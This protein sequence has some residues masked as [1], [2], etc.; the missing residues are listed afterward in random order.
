MKKKLIPAYPGFT[1][2][3]I[4]FTIDDGIIKWDEKFISICRPYGI[5]GTFNLCSARMDREDGFYRED[6]GRTV[7]L[8]DK[9][10]FDRFFADWHQSAMTEVE[11][12][13]FNK[14]KNMW[15]FIYTK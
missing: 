2:R 8:F 9:E 3:A 15:E 12:V 10:Q 13:R 14:S 11:T 7:R 5:R 4:T 6:G 1:R